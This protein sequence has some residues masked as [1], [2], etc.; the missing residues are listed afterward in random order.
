MKFW[1]AMK[2]LE[3]GKKVRRTIWKENEYLYVDE[4]H[5]I[6]D[7]EGYYAELCTTGKDDWEVYEPKKDVDEKFKE[8][9]HYLKDENGFTNGQYGEFIYNRNETDHLL[10]FYRQLLEM[11]K[12]YKLD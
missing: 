12:Y 7:E 8:L 9:Y 2:C 6:K 4:K 10:E 1:E 11:A 5:E 3:E